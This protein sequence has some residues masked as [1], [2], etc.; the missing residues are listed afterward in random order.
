MDLWLRLEPNRP[1][2]TGDKG[3]E[4]D[5]T[6]QHAAR[7]ATTWLIALQEDPDDPALRQRFEAW[8]RSSPMNDAAWLATESMLGMADALAPRHADKWGGFVAG[9]RRREQDRHTAPGYFE[10]RWRRVS[11]RR[12]LVGAVNL[13][14]AAVLAVVAVPLVLVR[15]QA[16]HVTST[17]ELREIAL[18]DGSMVTLS[19]GSAIAVSSGAGERTVTLI[20][21]EAFFTVRPDATRPFRVVAG[22]VRTTVLGTE[23]DVRRDG[24]GVTVTV[25]QG[26][27]QVDSTVSGAQERLEAGDALRVDWQGA[28]ARATDRVPVAAG[29]RRGQLL[30]QNETLADAVDQLRRYYGGTIILADDSLRGRRITGVYNL[31]DPEE[32]LRGIARAHGAKVRRVTPWVLVVSAE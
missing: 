26:I 10:H 5:Q 9:R 30:A 6:R 17:A 8:R 3:L 19:G 23:F 21:G 18:D 1:G 12:L 28:A 7:E 24:A 31:A 2:C 16:D 4:A 15:L 14:V 27:V 29:W 11:P 32:A 25:E 20:Q 13:A 22:S